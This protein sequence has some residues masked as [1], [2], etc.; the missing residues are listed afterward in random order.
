MRTL[1]RICVDAE[2]AITRKRMLRLQVPNNNVRE[3]SN[4]KDVNSYF[5]MFF[6]EGHVVKMRLSEREDNGRQG[7]RSWQINDTYIIAHTPTH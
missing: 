3:D 2:R 4:G 5:Y 1:W 6:L 7:N